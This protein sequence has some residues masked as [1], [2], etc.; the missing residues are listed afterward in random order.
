[1][2]INPGSIISDDHAH[3]SLCAHGLKSSQPS[4]L[5]SEKEVSDKNGEEGIFWAVVDG[6][7][8]DASEFLDGH[9]GGRKK[10]L[11]TNH[12]RIGATGSAFGFSFSKGR[13]AHFPKTGKIF[14]EGVKRYLAGSLVDGYLAPVDVRFP[15][16]GKIVILGR[17]KGIPDSN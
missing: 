17:L 9:P 3:E 10:V 6:Y 13:N 7:V 1:M 16:H 14:Q 2:D 11:A 8:V 5:I 15:P 4:R 12:P